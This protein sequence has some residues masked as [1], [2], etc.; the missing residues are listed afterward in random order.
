M[1][2]Q[3]RAERTLALMMIFFLLLVMT[4][5]SAEDTCL[6]SVERVRVVG[7]HPN[8]VSKKQALAISSLSL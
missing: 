2:G 8:E 3:G 6:P 7:F 1:K 4:H 5:K